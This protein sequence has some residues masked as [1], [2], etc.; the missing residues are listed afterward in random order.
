MKKNKLTFWGVRGS[1]PTPEKDKIEYGGH[2][3]CVSL[4]TQNNEI[5]IID[6]GTGMK[7]LGEQIMGDSSSPETIHIILS[8]YHW[9]HMIGLL[10]FA[11]LFSE[12]FNIHF[13]GKKD[14]MSMD[15]IFNHICHPIFW[16]ISMNDFKAKINFHTIDEEGFNVSDSIHIKSQLHGHPNGALSFRVYSNDKNF[17]YITDC[18]HPDSQLNKKLI[19]LADNTDLLIHDSHF[20]EEDLI[21]HKGWGHSSWAQSVS[22]AK[23]SNA[24]QLIL[25]HHNPAY[26]DSKLKNIESMAQESFEKT[27]SARQ[28]LV[29][30]L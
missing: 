7:N 25:F 24:K 3:S 29:I 6:M 1:Y 15:E 22:M 11:P 27:V 26:S 4:H 9:D 16:P 14:D 13:Y 2:T 30:Y 8:H 19:D 18:E 5:L 23:E 17:T 12:K 10:A 20:T 28:G 21:E